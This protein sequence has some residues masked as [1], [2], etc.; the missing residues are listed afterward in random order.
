M[1]KNV[2]TRDTEMFNYSF[3][4]ESLSYESTF[5]LADF[6]VVMTTNKKFSLNL[7][8]LKNTSKMI[9]TSV[10]TIFLF[11]ILIF[12]LAPQNHNWEMQSHVL[13]TKK[14]D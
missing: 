14:T 9:R 1:G 7:F 11:F 4:M 3:K 5:K 6:V 13:F 10:V 12:K 8:N 2:T